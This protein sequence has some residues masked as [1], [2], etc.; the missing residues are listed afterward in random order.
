[1]SR[2][3]VVIEIETTGDKPNEDRVCALALIALVD[4]QV[5]PNGQLYL[6]FDPGCESSAEASEQHGLDDWLLRHQ[7]PFADYAERLRTIL[8]QAPLVIG[9]D[10]SRRMSFVNREFERAGLEP[11]RPRGFCTREA[12]TRRWPKESP[13]LDACLSR[14]GIKREQRQHGASEDCAMTAALFLF[15]QGNMKPDIRYSARPHNLQV[16]PPAPAPIPPRDQT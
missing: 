5:H 4:G 1:M 3:A 8:L 16:P 2:N 14:L 13:A 15:F 10:I 9:H 12:A 6:L 11:I 7:K